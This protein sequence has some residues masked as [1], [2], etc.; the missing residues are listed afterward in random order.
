MH[1]DIEFA[2]RFWRIEKTHFDESIVVSDMAKLLH[3]PS[4]AYDIRVDLNSTSG[5]Q[6]RGI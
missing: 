4:V 6:L 1:L 5:T 2:K 3:L